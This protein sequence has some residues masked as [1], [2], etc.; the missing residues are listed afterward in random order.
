MCL[1]DQD[2]AVLKTSLKSHNQPSAVQKTSSYL[3]NEPIFA[4]PLKTLSDIKHILDIFKLS[5]SPK[6]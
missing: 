6:Y 1:I 4:P 3:H 5:R 2:S